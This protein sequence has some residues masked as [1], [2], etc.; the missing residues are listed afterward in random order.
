M[1]VCRKPNKIIN[2][3]KKIFD[4]WFENW[5]L[6]HVP[7]LTNQQK[8]YKSDEKLSVGDVVLFLKNDSVLCSDYHYGMVTEIEVSSDGQVRRVAIK[9]KNQTENVFQE[10]F[11]AIKRNVTNH[12]VWKNQGNSKR[13]CTNKRPLKYQ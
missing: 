10:T 13:N 12:T 1:Q 9:Y 7:K 5:L 8:W 6:S 4:C 2:E 3:N 11:V